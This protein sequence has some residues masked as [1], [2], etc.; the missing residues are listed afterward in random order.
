MNSHA[1]ESRLEPPTRYMGF[2]INAIPL[3]SLGQVQN[4]ASNI[5]YANQTTIDES[6]PNS[7]EE[8]SKKLSR[9]LSFPD[10]IVTPRWPTYDIRRYATLWFFR[11]FNEKLFS[12]FLRTQVSRTKRKPRTRKTATSTDINIDDF[13]Y[14]GLRQWFENE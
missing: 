12:F 9:F 3:L 10:R 11:F 7:A 13:F 5:T 14:S 1:Q 2:A 8:L 6:S 4:R